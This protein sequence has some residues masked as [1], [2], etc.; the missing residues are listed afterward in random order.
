MQESL[1]KSKKLVAVK[2]GTEE[3]CNDQ[4]EIVEDTGIQVG[5]V[6]VSTTGEYGII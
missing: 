3:K 2:R 5:E 1:A 6:T 4:Q